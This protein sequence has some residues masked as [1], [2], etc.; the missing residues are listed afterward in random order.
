MQKNAVGTGAVL[1]LLTSFQQ[2]VEKWLV[3]FSLALASLGSPTHQLEK[4]RADPVPFV[5]RQFPGFVILC[6]E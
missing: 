5:S 1:M 4:F 2:P 6:G 3:D